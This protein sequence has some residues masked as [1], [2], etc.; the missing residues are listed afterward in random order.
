METRT[1]SV[2]V[3]HGNGAQQFCVRP[4]AEARELWRDALANFSGASLYH[5][6]RWLEV[7]RRAYAMDLWVA[8]VSE[9]PSVRAACVLAGSKNPL[10]RRFVALPFS[11]FCE[12][13]AAD[14]A[15]LE[16]LFSGLASDPLTRS[17]CEIR[18]IPA[19]VP[20]QVADC[21][22]VFAV[23]MAR[24]SDAI[25]RSLGGEFRRKLARNLR[26][27][28]QAGLKVERGHE[29]DHVTRFY[30]LLLE[31]RRRLGVP[32][33]PLRLFM[34]VRELFHA[35]NLIEVW[36]ATADGRDAAGL[37][38]LKDRDRLYY[39]WSARGNVNAP[40]ANHL[41]VW[42]VIEEYAGAASSLDLGRA[43][44]RNVGLMQFKKEMGGRATPLPY[45]FFPKRPRHI[46]PEVPSPTR[47]ALTQIW[48]RLPLSA[49][50]LIGSALYGY[51]T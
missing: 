8:S 46:S 17:G 18:G 22:T 35:D 6:E 23:D 3:T 38:L 41:L 31:T 37:I 51:L 42:S 26:Q 5:S 49:T 11:D 33:Q 12:P 47:R 15:A 39:K 48:R 32:P 16:R 50:R 19:P 36:L 24:T 28:R 9:G 14:S 40:G 10:S 13:L 7:L 1:D 29:P 4:F 43:D 25:E 20:W 2:I 45:A 27:A 30:R 34:M 21:Y 44:V